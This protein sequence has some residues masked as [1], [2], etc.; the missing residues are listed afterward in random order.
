MW[1]CLFANLGETEIA[2]LDF[3][4]FFS[5]ILRVQNL[6]PLDFPNSAPLAAAFE[7]R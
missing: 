4:G 1:K 2:M 6:T 5:V 3:S 7:R